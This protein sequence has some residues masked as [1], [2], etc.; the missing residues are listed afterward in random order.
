MKVAWRELILHLARDH[1]LD[2]TT[3]D[4][5]DGKTVSRR[6]LVSE[7]LRRL[8]YTGTVPPVPED[9]S[10]LARAIEGHRVSRVAV[11][12]FDLAAHR[13]DYDVNLFS[14]LRH[15]IMESRKLVLLIQSRQ[16]FASLLPRG[17]P[18]SDIDIRTVEI[19]GRT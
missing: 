6:G 18:L 12:H 4:L 1:F 3:V 8:G 5:Q 11:T 10:E 14:A 15:V 7:I 17:H 19:K 16:P 13:A 9:L 2:L